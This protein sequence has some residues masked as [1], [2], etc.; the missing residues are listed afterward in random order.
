MVLFFFGVVSRP[1]LI[2]DEVRE[3]H[4]EGR[5]A[6]RPGVVSLLGELQVPQE[7]GQG[8]CVVLPR[9]S[10]LA[11]YL[12]SHIVDRKRDVWLF[13]C[14]SLFVLYKKVEVKLQPNGARTYLLLYHGIS[15][16]RFP[17]L[18]NIG[19][20]CRFHRMHA[21]STTTA[22]VRVRTAYM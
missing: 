1:S 2:S 8:A 20:I 22:A 5:R 14:F 19:C 15:L 11:K 7:E 4:R 3:E 9:L 18:Y 6:V 21:R 12:V 13:L 10:S 16:S 17:L